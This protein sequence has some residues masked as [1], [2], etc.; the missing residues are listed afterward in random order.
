MAKRT[1]L[2]PPIH[3][4]IVDTNI[5]WLEDKGPAANPEFDKFW[6][7]YKNLL[8]MELLIPEVVRDELVVQH[9]S[10]GQKLMNQVGDNL[11]KLSAITTKKHQHRLSPEGMKKHIRA[12]FEQWVSKVGAKIVDVPLSEIDWKNLYV[13][14]MWRMP[15]FSP[16]TQDTKGRQVEKG[17][18]DALI[19]ETVVSVVRKEKKREANI[20]FVSNDLVLRECLADEL[21]LET[22]FHSFESLADFASYVKLTRESYDKA[23][24][25]KLIKRAA[26]RF[27]TSNDDQ[28]L[29]IKEKIGVTMLEATTAWKMNDAVLN[30][31]TESEQLNRKKLLV[32][33]DPEQTLFE[34]TSPA[35]WIHRGGQLFLGAHEFREKTEKRTYKWESTTYSIRKFAL[36]T[37]E[38]KVLEERINLL[39]FRV[40][41]K[42]NV[43]ADARFYDVTLEEVKVVRKEFRAPTKDEISKFH[44]DRLGVQAEASA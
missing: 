34:T 18:R 20:V 7:E 40:F 27:F 33:G 10:S 8:P 36:I 38:N 1:K 24:N 2:V 32:P 44:F 6:E 5:L 23:F 4:L 41:W 43:K 14:A 15:P 29:W 28:C 35:R 3:L 19:L 11:T 30:Q 37:N 42:A 31:P 21:W 22:Q 26:E 16:V 17:F 9:S 13:K 12:K 25:E 39:E